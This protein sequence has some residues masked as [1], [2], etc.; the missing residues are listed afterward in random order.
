MDGWVDGERGQGGG[1]GFEFARAGEREDKGGVWVLESE[2]GLWL[3]LHWRGLL[4]DT[5]YA[6]SSTTYNHNI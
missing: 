2:D 1:I 4:F 3:N 5:T 6:T